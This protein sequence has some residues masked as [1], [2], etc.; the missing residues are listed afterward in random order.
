[1]NG[2]LGRTRCFLYIG[3][4]LSEL[5]QFSM[6]VN[7]SAL[8][9][10][11]PPVQNQ[12]QSRCSKKARPEEEGTGGKLQNPASHVCGSPETLFLD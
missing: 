8:P 6:K 3:K 4:H 1:M 7:P 2:R 12:R 10:F 11:L 9:L 5:V